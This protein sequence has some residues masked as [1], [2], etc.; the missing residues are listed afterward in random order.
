[1][2]GLGR[3]VGGLYHLM[4]NNLEGHIDS[5]V[6]VLASHSVKIKPTLDS[7][8]NF[9]SIQIKPALDS[10][11][12][13][14]SVQIKPALNSVVAAVKIPANVWHSRL[15]H[16]SDSRLHLLHD[17]IPDY[18]S[19]SNKKCFVCPL[20]KHHRIS[21]P[22][23]ITHSLHTFDLI[24]CDIW[25]LFSSPSLNGSK[26]FLTIV[27]DHNWFTKFL[28]QSFFHL[29]ETQFSLKIKCIRTD[30]GSEFSMTNFFSSKGVIHQLTCVEIPQQ[31]AIAER[32]HQHLLNVAR[33]LRFQANLPL[34]F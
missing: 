13:F 29:V 20:A 7:I 27:D 1:M 5:S 31:N 9:N 26:F 16:L 30:N 28:I 25:G 21:F 33:T 34:Q 15:G 14:N 24:R 10:I 23:S 3:E 4:L 11:C 19:S 32:K 2:I 17:V 12:N 8:C 6:L 18:S 22:L